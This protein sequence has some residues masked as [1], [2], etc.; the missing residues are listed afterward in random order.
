MFYWYGMISVSNVHFNM[1][2]IIIDC[3]YENVGLA[4]R[5]LYGGLYIHIYTYYID[6]QTI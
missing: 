2:K 3:V 1:W 6:M 4:D 5:S